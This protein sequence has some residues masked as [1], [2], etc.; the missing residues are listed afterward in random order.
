MMVHPDSHGVSRAPWYSG[1]H[2]KRHI[3]SPTRL[4]RSMASLSR[5]LRLKMHFVTLRTYGSM[6]TVGPTTPHKQ[7]PPSITLMRFRLFPFRSPLLRESL[8]IS[9][10]PGTE[11]FHFPGFPPTG[12]YDP[13]VKCLDKHLWLPHSDILGSKSARDSPRRFAARCVLHRL[14]SPRHPPCA[15]HT[16][17]YQQCHTPTPPSSTHPQSETH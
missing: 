12:P 14:L 2:L 4:A 17:S 6:F 5:T 3:S 9:F 7:R 1:T 8:V 11:M 15:L 16:L 10:P 13:V